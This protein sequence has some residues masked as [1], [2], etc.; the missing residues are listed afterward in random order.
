MCLSVCILKRVILKAVSLVLA[1][2]SAE[3]ATEGEMGHGGKTGGEGRCTQSL[4]INQSI[5]K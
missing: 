3:D 5:H 1:E 4:G 2:C